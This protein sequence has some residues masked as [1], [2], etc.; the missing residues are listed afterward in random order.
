VSTHRHP[1]KAL[2]TASP[3][4]L[5]EAQNTTWVTPDSLHTGYD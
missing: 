5:I 2:G 3:G 4:G 1:L